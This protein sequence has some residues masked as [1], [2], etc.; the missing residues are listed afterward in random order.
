MAFA[1]V[2]L[3]LPSQASDADIFDF[4]REEARV[5]T[6]ARQPQARHEAPATVHVVTRHQIEAFGSHFLW[7]ALRGVPGVD[8]ASART[9]HGAVSIRGLNKLQNSRMLVLVDGRRALDA[10]V[11]S[12]DWEALP[13][14]TDEIERLEIVEGPA[15]ALYGAN[16][17]NGVVN[18]ITSTPAQLNGGR[19]RTAVGDRG[20]KSG[21][22][23]QGRAGERFEYKLSGEWRGVNRFEDADRSAS[24]SRKGHAKVGYLMGAGRSASLEL[25]GSWHETDISSGGLGRT[26]E[27]G[28]RQFARADYL[29]ASGGQATLSWTGGN[30]MLTEFATNPQ[31]DIDFDTFSGT[32]QKAVAISPRFGLVS[33]VEYRRDVVDSDIA[34][35]THHLWSAFSQGHWHLAAKT[36]VWV[37]GRIDRHPHTGTELSPRMSI[38]YELAATQVLRASAGTSYRNPSLLD[39]H[40]DL[41]GSLDLSQLGLQMALLGDLRT[42]DFQVVGSRALKPERMRFAELAHAGRFRERLRTHLAAFHYRLDDLYAVSEPEVALADSATVTALISFTNMGQTRGT[43][44]E[45]GVTCEAAPSLHLLANHSYQ[46]LTGTIDSQAADSGTPHHKTTAGLAYEKGRF[47]LD[48]MVHRVGETRW[49]RNAVITTGPAFAEVGAYTLVNLRAGYALSGAL[50]GWQVELHVFDLF[51]D[52]HHEILPAENELVRA[53]SGEIIRSRRSFRLTYA[54]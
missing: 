29:D 21:S 8:V 28:R 7:D 9:A 46:K 45:F 51:D 43:G 52:R 3:P 34:T 13:I 32:A 36:D 11:E 22:F 47:L 30:S 6:A 40:V 35:A 12:P 24:E 53:Q 17:I 41:S 26:T 39:N 15:S 10:H 20:T 14:P 25:G 23:V 48:A 42:L 44:L 2:T 37:S 18:I 27:E 31:S 4:F 54:F 50:Q 5:I 19:V 33:G 1:C 49:N 16:A 38:L